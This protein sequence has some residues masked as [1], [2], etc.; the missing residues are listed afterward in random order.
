MAPQPGKRIVVGIDLGYT[1]TGVAYSLV[2]S[3]RIKE[4]GPDIISSWP[5]RD[6][7]VF[8]VPTQVAYMTDHKGPTAWGFMRPITRR[9]ETYRTVEKY[10]K[11]SL[12]SSLL[13]ETEPDDEDIDF[14][15]DVKKW[16]TDFLGSL[17]VWINQTLEREYEVSLASES[18]KVEYVFSVPTTWTPE[19]VADYQKIINNAGYSEAANHTAKIGLTE[20]EAAAV[21]TSIDHAK[22]TSGETK[23]ECSYVMCHLE[24]NVGV[25]WQDVSIFKVESLKDDIPQLK[26]LHCVEGQLPGWSQ[27]A[28]LTMFASIGD[29]AGSVKIDEAFNELVR[30]RLKLIENLS[31]EELARIADTMTDE[32][33]YFQ[34]VKHNVGKD[35][36]TLL[37]V[38]SIEVPEL[39]QSYSH[40][41]AQIIDGKMMFTRS[42]IEGLFETQ[43]AKI[44]KLIDTQLSYLQAKHPRESVQ[45][46]VLSGG[47][48]SSEYV[49][50]RIRDHLVLNKTHPNAQNINVIISRDPQ[51]VVC[52]GL[53]LS[54]LHE[55]FK[56]SVIPG[57]CSRESYGI[58]YD[59]PWDQSIHP[60]ELRVKHSNG[61]YYVPGKIDWLIRKND[62]FDR[63]DP[64]T[65]K[66]FSRALSFRNPEKFVHHEIVKFSG[67]LEHPE[68]VVPNQTPTVCT[69]KCNLGPIIEAASQSQQS[70]PRGIK[71]R[72]R[73]R[74]GVRTR[75]FLD[76]EYKICVHRGP[77]D[78]KFEL[79]FAEEKSNSGEVLVDWKAGGRVAFLDRGDWDTE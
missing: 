58:T 46:L 22:S 50:Q 62:F 34:S 68:R 54:Q 64:S 43:I 41:Q 7:V 18:T 76:V 67:L 14:M 8:K 77:A 5:N 63:A 1:H 73:H 25:C 19:V 27:I 12:D 49:Q 51:L 40:A 2:E 56:I 79:W 9:R 35:E 21:Y 31:P 3:D 38:I 29:I 24:S 16:F 55:Y 52:R 23:F 71:I 36:L 59:E 30:S 66:L 69:I 57:L 65:T 61:R 33:G 37:S 44:L 48:G 10:F 26:Q 75:R 60:K 6:E 45:Y 70:L 47:L 78:M 15:A 4:S 28:L 39:G 17:R 42:E 72:H 53:V 74:L 20:A 13:S 32:V 11:L